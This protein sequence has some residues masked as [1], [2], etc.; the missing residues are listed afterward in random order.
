VVFANARSC[1]GL[2]FSYDLEHDCVI[3]AS[4]ISVYVRVGV[5]VGFPQ[6]IFMFWLYVGLRL[7]DVLFSC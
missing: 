7:C 4:I 5:Y 2:G 3:S 1:L 6:I